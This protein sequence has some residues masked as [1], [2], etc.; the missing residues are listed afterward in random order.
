MQISFAMPIFL[1]FSDQ[2]SGGKRLRGG[3][4]ASGGHTCGQ[5]PEIS[6][7]IVVMGDQNRYLSKLVSGHKPPGQTPPQEI[8][9]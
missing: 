6:Y 9:S 7:Q 8:W 4:T 2:M 3:Q 5:K 1:L